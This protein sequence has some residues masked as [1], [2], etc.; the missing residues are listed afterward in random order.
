MKGDDI[1]LRKQTKLW[2]TKSG[3]KLRICDMSNSHLIH[4]IKMMEEMAKI[5]SDNMPLLSFVTGEITHKDANDNPSDRYLQGT[6]Y[7]NLINEVKRRRLK[8]NNQ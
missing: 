1:I 6:I 3:I 8:W 4:S 7:V 5:A 2:P